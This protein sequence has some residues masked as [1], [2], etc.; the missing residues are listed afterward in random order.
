MLEHKLVNRINDEGV[1]LFSTLVKDYSEGESVTSADKLNIVLLK[2][3]RERK[4]SCVIKNSYLCY[5]SLL[6]SIQ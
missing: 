5:S 6:H 2:L 4:I 3:V 1:V